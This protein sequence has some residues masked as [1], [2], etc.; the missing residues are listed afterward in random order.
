MHPHPGCH[1]SETPRARWGHVGHCTRCQGR[2]FCLIPLFPPFA[3]A[4][5]A[6]PAEEGPCRGDTAAASP[7]PV[8]PPAAPCVPPSPPRHPQPPRKPPRPWSPSGGPRGPPHAH[9]MQGGRA[10]DG[11]EH[12]VHHQQ[13]TRTPR[14]PHA[15]GCALPTLPGA[16]GAAASL[17]PRCS[18]QLGGTHR[19]RPRGSTRVPAV[20]G[21][22]LCVR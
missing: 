20:A 19:R 9:P 3:P 18:W 8:P 11:R 10:V 14:G 22:G 17:L 2:I 5:P 16:H 6:V 1:P 12:C 15:G 7:G 4:A 21:G 13:P